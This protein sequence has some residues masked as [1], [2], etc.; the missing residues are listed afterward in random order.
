MEGREAHLAE[1]LQ[2]LLREAA[3][4]SV[5]LEKVRETWDPRAHYTRI[6]ARAHDLGQQLSRETQRRHMAELVAQA[7]VTAKCPSCG[8]CCNA[9]VVTRTVRAIDGPLEL[10][11]QRC[12]CPT[13]RRAFFPAAEG[14]GL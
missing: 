8:T 3:E 1:K 9:T 7:P 11:E 4:V 13:C 10:A 14:T 2:R 6:E 12:E 5:E